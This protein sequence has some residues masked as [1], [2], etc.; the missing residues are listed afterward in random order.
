[1]NLM[2]ANSQEIFKLKYLKYKQKYL[3]LKGG[4][5]C[6][7]LGFHQHISECWHDSYITMMLY[8]DNMSDIIQHILENY[9]KSFKTLEE[10]VEDILNFA[11]K[12]QNLQI[13]LPLNIDANVY[14][15]YK[16]YC[17]TYFLNLFNRYF[18]ERIKL[19]KDII[20]PKKGPKSVLV[21][22]NS[23]RESLYC[24]SNIFNILN[25]NNREPEEHNVI[26]RGG[27]HERDT[28]FVSCTY[29]YYLMNY[30][31]PDELKTKTI[32]E[33]QDLP[34]NFIGNQLISFDQLFDTSTSSQELKK[35]LSEMKDSI[36]KCD[37][38]YIGLLSYTSQLNKGNFIA[39]EN[40]NR[41]A[42]MVSM[43]T[44]D[45]KLY[46]YDN[47]GVEKYK[48]V[49]GMPTEGTNG[50]EGTEG[51]EG[52]NGTGKSIHATDIKEDYERVFGKGKFVVGDAVHSRDT[53]K[54]FVEFDWKKYFIDIINTIIDSIREK[55]T[56]NVLPRD[57]FAQE[58]LKFG[59]FFKD[60]WK[61]CHIENIILFSLRK[62]EEGKSIVE[63]EDK[64]Y[65]SMIKTLDNWNTLGGY[66]LDPAR[67]D[68]FILNNN[69]KMLQL[70]VRYQSFRDY[71]TKT[72]KLELLK[73]LQKKME[74]E[75]DK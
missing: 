52:T 50:T 19:E 57:Y 54:S 45:K 31:L 62:F 60:A 35:K 74:K 11:E 10:L 28:Y 61:N 23:L 21:R 46:Y 27:L 34:R 24:T 39:N 13:L 42:H 44:C 75:L 12:N 66:T 26:T 17:R 3:E 30:I 70:L 55:Q 47:E 16:R 48:L 8:T 14:G 5:I 49:G 58:R 71:L 41:I 2:K 73:Q 59:T 20:A 53:R 51:T 6:P 43:F 36:N 7:S 37:A 15:K 32:E 22:Q 64:Y 1:M 29:N 72:G 4:K 56:K 68:R 63:K 65:T 38:I 67:I 33:K 40:I 69:V 9:E 18:N 25:I